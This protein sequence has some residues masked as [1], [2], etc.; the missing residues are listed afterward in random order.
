MKILRTNLISLGYSRRLGRE[1]R[2][3]M[4][5]A[6]CAVFALQLGMQPA[7]A[8]G[9]ASCSTASC[10]RLRGKVLDNGSI[11][12]NVPVAPNV[13]QETGAAA[14]RIPFSISVDGDPLVGSAKPDQ[15]TA[16][17]KHRTGAQSPDSQRRTDTGLNAVDVQVKFDGLDAKPLLNVSTNPVRRS[18]KAGETIRLL[19]TSNYPAFIQRSE[20]RIFQSDADL[21]DQPVAVVPVQI[22]R[23]ARWVMPQTRNDESRFSYVLRVYDGEG[24]YDETVS[25][26]IARTDRELPPDPQRDA[27]S[28]APG[29]GDDNTGLRN[30]PIYGGAVTVYGHNVPDGYQVRALDDTVP[31]DA[32]RS[33][34]T[35][36]ILPP[37]EQDVHVALMSSPRQ[38][39]LE[40][41][42]Q[43][44]IPK[45]DWFY[46]GLADLTVGK[47][48]GDKG[49]EAVRPGEYDKVYTQGRLAF[50]LKGK[51]QGKYL[52]T[53]AGDTGNDK[54]ENMFRGMD[55]KDPR[56]LLRR[57]D[58]E[59]FYPVYGDDSVAVNDAPTNGKFYVRLDRGN[60]YVMW[61]RYK[62]IIKGTEFMRSE[63]ALYGGS[64]VYRSED[65]TSFGE[66]KTEVTLYAAQPDTLP[67][68]DEFL[69]TGGSAYFLKQQDI[70]VGSE[71]VTIEIRDPISGIVTDRRSLRYGEDYSID[72]LQG[73]LILKRPVSSST[74][75][76]DPVRE[77]A[78][79]GNR[80]FIIT[81]YEYTP[82]AGKVDGYAYGGRA[83]QWIDDRI[84]VGVTGMNEKTGA[85]DQRAFGADIQL[86]H[87]ERTFVEAEVSRSQGPGFGV[88]RSMDGGLTLSDI[89]TTGTRNRAAMAWRTRGQ[90]DLED[91]SIFGLKG[92]V[93]GYYQQKQAGFSTLSDQ[94]NADQRAWGSK[95]AIDITRQT[96]F[97]LS[98]D[99][100]K[101]GRVYSDLYPQWGLPGLPVEGRTKRKGTTSIEHR[102]NER[103]KAIF[104]LSYLDIN[105]PFATA[106][107]KRGY[108]GERTDAGVRLEY[109]PN[110]DDMYY[111][112]G[113]A[114][115]ARAGDI[116][117]GD[118]AGVG[119]KYKLTDKIDLNGEISY[120]T[121]GVGALAGIN[122][123]PTAEDTYYFGYRLDPDRAF[124]L[125]RAYDLIG[126]DRGSIVVGARRR[127]DEYWTVNAENNYDLFGRRNSLTKTYGVTY[128]PNE[129]WTLGGGFEAGTIEDDTIDPFTGLQRSNFDRK[130][131]SA[132]VGYKNGELITARLRAEA[133]FEDS[134]DGTRDRNTYLFAGGVN[135]KT[136]DNWRAFVK[137]D[138]VLSSSNPN[139]YY[140]FRDGNYVEATL[141][142][143]YRPVLN[144]R[145][146]AL[147]KY[148][149]VYDAPG[150]N[151]VSAISGT[152][153]GPAQRSH[154][155]SADFTYD[156]FPWLSIGAK[157]GMRIS[158][159][160]YR[161]F[162]DD[163]E[164]F[165]QWQKS[166]AHLGI[167]RADLHI[168]KA[169]DVMVEGRTMYMPEA[170]TTDFGAVAAV[171]RHVGDNL[172]IGVGYNFGRFSDDLRDLTLNDRGVFLNVIGKF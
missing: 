117:R 51:I 123:N 112:F 142:Y 94:I 120:G 41:R 35:Q 74:V 26:T 28:I 54:F 95:A 121:T 67:Q 69:G 146:N 58:P 100:F 55:A 165:G 50:Y 48:M 91:F 77:Q 107:H 126:R 76:T 101:E 6:S 152:E 22:N 53:A 72:Y 161:Q 30:I 97:T 73:V 103:W 119:A 49:I 19:A 110:A 82:A 105:N 116:T 140:S 13:E 169:W 162:D 99:D 90:V 137:V 33:F 128:T 9:A 170:K 47:R 167:L 171:Y 125:E 84:R 113:Q 12:R 21:P 148:S 143:A 24:H 89:Q 144:D 79:G 15:G 151:Q 102:F 16:P 61:G 129:L 131:V 5:L 145:L 60:S 109:T 4:L 108:N 68:R 81:Q 36:R 8:E 43:V 163:R 153:Y 135:W 166:S 37:G 124:D 149:W 20:I 133:R 138:S 29:M 150:M 130:A 168:V 93:S 18:Y 45:N 98:Y 34:V 141:G 57:V 172:K 158:D 32:S 40:F 122:Y 27:E 160:R 85:A 64:G 86:R 31:I 155:L 88:S 14:G 38:S 52:L 7:S 66:P 134:S 106:S 136:S 157:Y 56:Q 75:T 2:S 25:R 23:E 164:R 11:V 80:V 1:R 139:A 118:R 104:G 59:S 44:N 70:T 62:A 127:I 132:S 92:I 87:T 159:V 17:G 156:L 63:R 46:I 115:L 65:T 83:Q 96:R 147:F 42:R 71:T 10:T 111:A 154:I 3:R 39:A 78:L 114:T